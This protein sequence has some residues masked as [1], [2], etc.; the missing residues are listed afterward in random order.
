MKKLRPQ[1]GGV[2]PTSPR[3]WLPLF[4]LGAPRPTPTPPGPHAAPL[5]PCLAASQPAW[6]RP[7]RRSLRGPL[8]HPMALP[9][10]GSCR[11]GSAPLTPLT[12]SFRLGLPLTVGNPVRTHLLAL[13]A[14]CTLARMHVGKTGPRPGAC[15]TVP[16]W[17]GLT[18]FTRARGP[19]ASGDAACPV[20]LAPRPGCPRPPGKPSPTSSCAAPP[21]SRSFRGPTISGPTST[22][23]HPSRRVAPSCCWVTAATSGNRQRHQRPCGSSYA[24]PSWV[25]FG[26]PGAQPPPQPQQTLPPWPSEQQRQ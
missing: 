6:T 10:Q 22:L 7:Q 21:L 5:A 1:S 9:V 18:E 4:I 12:V 25:A 2:Q 15:Y 3:W 20:V 16:S 24:S 23:G 8:G 14:A 26:T 19:A 17:L 11:R 13:G